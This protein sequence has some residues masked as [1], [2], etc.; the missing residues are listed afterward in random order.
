[1]ATY[2]WGALNFRFVAMASS[3][4]ELHRFA[5]LFRQ[6]AVDFRFVGF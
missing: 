6:V 1:M 5:A 4:I 3:G 2:V